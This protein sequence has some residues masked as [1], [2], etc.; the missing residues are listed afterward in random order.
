MKFVK[1]NSST[2]IGILVFILVLVGIFA[3][4]KTFNPDESKAIYGT[5]LEGRKQVEITKSTKEEVEDKLKDTASKVTVKVSGRIINII[6]KVNAETSLETA[7]S[8]GDK[9]LEPFSDAEKKYYD[10]QMLIEN[11]KN[12]SQ[13][14]IIGYKQHSKESISWTKDRAES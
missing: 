7:K 8:L 3:V 4:K 14:P 12:T 2:I 5:R 13:F 11:D 1:K 9:A 10:F 6:V